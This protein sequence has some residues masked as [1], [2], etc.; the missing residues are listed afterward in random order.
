MQNTENQSQSNRIYDKQ[1]KTWFKVTPEQFREYD[2]WRTRLRKR[3]QYHGLCKCPRSKWWLCDG[4]C[5]DCEFRCIPG[6]VIS[7]DRPVE[8]DSGEEMSLHDVIPDP[9]SLFESALCDQDELEQLLKRLAELIPEAS[10]IGKLRL[11]K[12]KDEDIAERIGI[13][14][15][16]FRS[17]LSKAKEKL[18]SE[19]PDRF[20]F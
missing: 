14:R 20:H 10:E 11:Q 12:L 7:I 1:T 13:K 17:R 8:S 19:F 6:N 5:D 15:T 18:E 4:V 3:M 9:N 16:T 2:R